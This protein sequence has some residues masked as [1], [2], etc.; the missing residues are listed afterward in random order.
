[1]CFWWFFVC[2]CLFL[3]FACT[4][5]H[6]RAGNMSCYAYRLICQLARNTAC[7]TRW[8]GVGGGVCNYVLSS[9]FS[10]ASFLFFCF[11]PYLYATL[12]RCFII[13]HATFHVCFAT[14]ALCFII[15]H[16]T[17]VGGVGGV[18]GGSV[19][20]CTSFKIFKENWNTSHWQKVEGIERLFAT[21]LP[22]Q[23]QWPTW[24]PGQPSAEKA[25]LSVLLAQFA[26]IAQPSTVLKTLGK[27]A[28]QK[29]AA[30]R[31]SFQDAQKMQ[32]FSWMQNSTGGTA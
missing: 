22:P 6:H 19:F 10:C 7:Y 27:V 23:D 21:Q 3:C 1:M 15:W 9:A 14:L 25:C 32:F 24:Q 29:K 31:V 12:A 20:A 30:G 11:L 17:Q 5:L 18:G 4:L 28:K 13:W 16:A 8:W 26:E 2:F